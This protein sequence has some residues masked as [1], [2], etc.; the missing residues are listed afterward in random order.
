ME[1]VAVVL[2]VAE[3]RT[4]EFE[5][6]FREREVPVWRDLQGTRPPWSAPR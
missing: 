3:H 1:T 5:S 4:D 2:N 6:G